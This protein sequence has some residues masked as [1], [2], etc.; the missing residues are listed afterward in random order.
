MSGR[1]ELILIAIVLAL[2]AAWIGHACVW[3]STLNYLYG[4]RL[5]KRFLKPYRHFVGIV[6]G[7]APL[8]PILALGDF[9]LSTW[10]LPKGLWGRLVLGY[11]GLCAGIGLGV[12]PLVTLFRLLRPKPAAVRAES[13]HTLDLWPELGERLIGEGKWNRLPRL[14]FNC[15]FRVDFTEL[16]LVLSNLP[17]EWDGVTLLLLSDFH[18]HG[19]PS[20]AFFERVIAEV[21]SQPPA[22]VVALAGDYLD[23]HK[24]HHWIPELLGKLRWK[25]CGLAI[26]GNHD[27]PY[28]PYRTRE[29]LAKLGYHVLSDRWEEVELRGVKCV[30]VGHEGPWFRRVPDLSN[31]PAEPFR[32]CL[33]HTPDN[34]YWGIANR[35]GLM[36]CGHVHGGQIRLPVIGSIFVPSI[37]S[38][39]FDTGVFEQR[40]T[41]MV[42]G[43]GLS[44]KEPLRFRCNPQVIRITLRP[45]NEPAS[46]PS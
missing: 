31:A 23:T 7:I 9:D 28:N 14:P 3:T 2:A 40:G 37:Y 30:A 38:R 25:E 21:N 43:R 39:R 15:V 32:L 44:G 20:A 4:C 34:F 35:I 11:V 41:V 19:T 29:E 12:F 42:V 6:I 16:T 24:H 26:L 17:P 45:R 13:T 1:S 33:S 5:P 10:A 22:D 8:V 27:G 18:F 36:L 46:P